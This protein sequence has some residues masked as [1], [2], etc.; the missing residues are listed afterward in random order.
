MIQQFYQSMADALILEGGRDRL[1]AFLQDKLADELV[2][3]AEH[4]Q[5]DRM[6]QAL[7]PHDLQARVAGALVERKAG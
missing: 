3:R 1:I 2:A 5:R 4:L 7:T 6:H